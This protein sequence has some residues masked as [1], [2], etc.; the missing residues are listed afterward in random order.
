MHLNATSRPLRFPPEFVPL[1]EPSPD[2]V[3]YE[4]I[5]GRS[6][7]LRNVLNQISQVAPTDTT[8]LICGET[9]TG[10]ERFARAVHNLSGRRG[11]TFVKCNCAAIPTTLLSGPRGAADRLG[12]NRSTL[13]F[14]MKKL[15]IER[16][17]DTR[18]ALELVASR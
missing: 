13:L 16:P 17:A 4:G 11:H 9:G 7:A 2:V 1:D 6:A 12:M 15:G 14:R 18:E 5:I 10:K 3:I 8:V